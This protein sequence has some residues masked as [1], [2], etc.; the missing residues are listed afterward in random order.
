MAK[1]TFEPGHTAAEFC[2]RHMMVTY[3]RGH[4]KDVH[5]TLNFDLKNPAD[6][7]VDVTID[8]RKLWTGEPARDN[9]LRSA[10]FLDVENFPEIHFHGGQVTVVGEVDYR[11]TGELT[12]RGTTRNATLDVH[13]LGQWQTPWWEDGVDK[14]PKT[15]A[16]F[17]AKTSINRHDFGVSWNDTMDKGGIVVSNII[18]ITIDAEAI[19]EGE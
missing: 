1:W 3:V 4:F 9:H 8:A 10:D 2:A 17:V 14:G 15:R 5:G 18:D 19:Y 12:I 16:G 11:A 7:S 6:S 13:Y